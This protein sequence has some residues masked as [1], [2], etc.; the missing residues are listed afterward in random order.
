MIRISDV[1]SFLDDEGVVYSFEGDAQT[2]IDGFS[3]LAHYKPGSFTWIKKKDSLPEG[4][5]TAQV[6]LAIIAKGEGIRG[7][8]QNTITTDRSKFAFF[9]TIEKFYDTNSDSYD[10]P[11]G[12]C[13][14]FST[15]VKLGKNVRIGH[16]CTLEGDITIGDNTVIWHGVTII[17]R[18]RIGNNCTIHSGCVIGHDGY[19]YTEDEANHKLMVK[20]Y[21]GVFIGSDVLL[22][23]GI[24]ISR[25]TIDDTIIEDGTKIDAMAH[26]AHNCHFEENSASAT[27]CSFSGSVHVGR[28]AYIA[29][30]IIRNQIHIGADA[31]VGLGSVVVKDVAD[32]EL[33]AGVPAKPFKK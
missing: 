33:V 11:I 6:T 16:N 7:S 26:I 10:E 1:L 29:G 31:F 27:P 21:G 15:S 4:F 9:S 8:F 2:A 19:A 24:C 22:G 14:Y 32:G 28:N 5:N 20:H 18:V 30:T 25:G 12:K 3:S 17:N 13:A 23:E